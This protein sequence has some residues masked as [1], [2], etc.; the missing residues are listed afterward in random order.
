MIEKIVAFASR[1]RFQFDGEEKMQRLFEI[2]PTLTK[3]VSFLPLCNSL[4]DGSFKLERRKKM[5][6]FSEEQEVKSYFC[7]WQDRIILFSAALDPR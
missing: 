7:I 4:I 3:S 5:E 6:P 2:W 1:H